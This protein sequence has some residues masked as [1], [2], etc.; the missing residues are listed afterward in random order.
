MHFIPLFELLGSYFPMINEKIPSYGQYDQDLV[1]SIE[2]NLPCYLASDILSVWMKWDWSIQNR[3]SITKRYDHHRTNGKCALIWNEQTVVRRRRLPV[4]YLLQLIFIR[5]AFTVYYWNGN[6]KEYSVE[7]QLHKSSFLWLLDIQHTLNGSK[8]TGRPKHNNTRAI[9]K[10][11]RFTFWYLV[12][13]FSIFNF[14][15]LTDCDLHGNESTMCGVVPIILTSLPLDYAFDDLHLFAVC[16]YIRRT[17]WFLV[18]SCVEQIHGSLDEVFTIS[19]F[20]YQSAKFTKFIR[21]WKIL[22]FAGKVIGPVF[23]VGQPNSHQMKI[24]QKAEQFKDNL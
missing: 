9:L 4:S 19:S 6:I 13:C 21:V 10:A 11:Q 16:I 20:Y 17:K 24:W 14:Y 15:S 22:K 8:C 18:H 23:F 1:P 3:Q 2:W 7:E 5:T 12:E